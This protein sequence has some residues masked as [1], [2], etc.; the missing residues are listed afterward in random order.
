[1]HL[2]DFFFLN[3][4]DISE[5]HNAYVAYIQPFGHEMLLWVRLNAVCTVFH[6]Q[7]GH[8]PAGFNII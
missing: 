6:P 8:M 4:Y 2:R 1:M 3:M 5:L 7:P